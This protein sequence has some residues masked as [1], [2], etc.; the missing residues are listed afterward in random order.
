M[1]EGN[2][3]EIWS[4]KD[5]GS[6]DEEEDY[7]L[8]SEGPKY[9]EDSEETSGSEHNYITPA[10]SPEARSRVSSP[11]RTGNTDSASPGTS[12]QEGTP[13]LNPVPEEPHANSMAATDVRLPTFNGN[14]ME[15][16]KQHWFLCDVVWMVRLVH[17][18]DIKKVQMITNLS[19][20]ALDWFMKFCIVPVETP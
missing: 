11:E 6:C 5:E 15:D 16:P 1:F 4:C 2:E 19:G 12:A 20:C 9:F 17:S 18:A 13:P 3:H 10:I 14:G 8:I 7:N